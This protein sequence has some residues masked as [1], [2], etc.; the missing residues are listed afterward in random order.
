M[1]PHFIK[2]VRVL[3]KSVCEL[4]NDFTEETSTFTGK[5]AFVR[6][7]NMQNYKSFTFPGF[8]I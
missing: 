1:N 6:N 4:F 7:N 3:S 8:I 5:E 2:K